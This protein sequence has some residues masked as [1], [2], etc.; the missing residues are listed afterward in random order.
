MCKTKLEFWLNSIRLHAIITCGTHIKIL[1]DL[2]FYSCQGIIIQRHVSAKLRL[3]LNSSCWPFVTISA[4]STNNHF[5][6]TFTNCINLK[7]L[8]LLDSISLLLYPPLFSWII[9]TIIIIQSYHFY[10]MTSL[11]FYPST[12]CSFA[13]ASSSF[14]AERPTPFPQRPLH[15][16]LLL[17]L[18]KVK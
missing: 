3:W 12:P 15:R 14:H 4:A 18:P 11:P 6:R 13:K 7:Q 10:N 8:R 17:T 16:T 2:I 5:I 1:A 9:F